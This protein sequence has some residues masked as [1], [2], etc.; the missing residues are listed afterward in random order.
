MLQ[1][2]FKI[3]RRNLIKNKVY[4][5]TN[6]LGLS[7]GLAACVL[8]FFFVQDELSYDTHFEDHERIFRIAGEYDQGGDSKTQSAS[9]SYLLQPLI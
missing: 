9:T 1:T 4:S 7:V 5:I 3:A 6:I 2:Y 8:I